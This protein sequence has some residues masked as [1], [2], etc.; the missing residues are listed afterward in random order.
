VLTS[1]SH[2]AHG[3]SRPFVVLSTLALWL[4]AL[5][6]EV[7][8][9]FLLLLVLFSDNVDDLA[10]FFWFTTFPTFISS[11]LAHKLVEII[12][13]IIFLLVTS[14]KL[15][16]SITLFFLVSMLLLHFEVLDG[17]VEL[18]VLETLFLLFESFDFHLLL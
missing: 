2:T 11:F 9:L 14:F 8:F 4:S 13:S 6:F 5:R 3:F 12:L 1:T 18:F 16:N 10:L 17:F 7:V 15:L